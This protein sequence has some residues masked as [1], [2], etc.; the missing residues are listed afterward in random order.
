MRGEGQ[1]TE[2]TPTPNLRAGRRALEGLK[3]VSVLEDWRWSEDD[4]AWVLFCRLSPELKPT[5]YVPATTDWYVHAS[6]S[7]PWGSLSF[8]PAKENGLTVTFFHQNY[9]WVGLDHLPRRTG[10]VCLDTPFRSLHRHLFDVEPFDAERRL[11]WHIMR[12]LGWLQLASKDELVAAGHPYELPQFQIRA[13]PFTVIFSQG[14]DSVRLWDEIPDRA[15]IVDFVIFNRNPALY[16]VHAYRSMGG[17]CIHEPSWG[18]IINGVNGNRAKGMWLRLYDLPVLPPWQAP[19]TWGELREACHQQGIDFDGTLRR[20]FSY[21]AIRGSY[22]L[23]IGF[24]I[25]EEFGGEAS[26]YHWQALKL[27]TLKSKREQVRGFRPGEESAWNFNRKSLLGDDSGIGWLKSINWHA[28][29]LGSRGMMP[30]SVT[31]KRFAMIGGGAVGAAVSEMLVRAG[32]HRFLVEDGED[33]EA[34]NL[35]RHTL[36]LDDLHHLKAGSLARRLNHVSPHAV[37]DTISTEFPPENGSDRVKLRDADVVIDCTGSDEVL[38]QMTV[39]PW[40]GVKIF[41]SIAL[42]MSARRIFCFTASGSHF[43]HDMFRE[44]IAPW[45][46]LELKE[47]AGRELPREGVGCW[48]P[49]FQARSDDVW[50]LSSV[51]VKALQRVVEAG[52]GEP[53]LE[54]FEQ[55]EIEGQFAGVR[56]AAL[57][58]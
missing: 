31:S 14:A 43:P 11:R 13:D 41:S 1:F 30:R 45:L 38:Y 28:D 49:V 12:A 3:G 16:I 10:K 22:L 57:K 34:G 55:Y 39:F 6:E 18:S 25:P 29:Q 2:K 48:H 35:C 51:A 50:L 9:N 15:G 56:R 53:S 23:L 54:V 36:T 27:P 52:S 7:Y 58:E 32:N 24:P 17:R 33:F 20:M 47:N 42:G 19:A 44:M 40:G 26:R 46:E 21:D 8:Y 37:V 4:K 5:E